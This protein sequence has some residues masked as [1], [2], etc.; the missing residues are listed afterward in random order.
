MDLAATVISAVAAAVMLVVFVLVAVPKHLHSA[1]FAVAVPAA[2]LASADPVHFLLQHC[3]LVAAAVAVLL[4]QAAEDLLAFGFAHQAVALV[5]I[6]APTSAFFAVN[7]LE[8]Y[9]RPAQRN[10]QREKMQR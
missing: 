5:T 6:I 9:L 3:L 7:L 1:S 8:Y 10:R 2:S 4:R